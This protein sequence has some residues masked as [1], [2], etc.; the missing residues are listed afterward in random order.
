MI[1]LNIDVETFI[2]RYKC[3]KSQL[4]W[5]LKLGFTWQIEGQ[6]FYIYFRSICKIR[7]ATENNPEALKLEF[8]KI[9]IGLKTCFSQ[10]TDCKGEFT[11]IFKMRKLAKREILRFEWFCKK[12]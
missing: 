4:K 1:D 9:M 11:L 3:L 7:K 12:S 2:F 8:A 6:I 5:H 10:T